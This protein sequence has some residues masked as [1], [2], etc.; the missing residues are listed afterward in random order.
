MAN[1]INDISIATG[2]ILFFVFVAVVT[3]FIY[4]EFDVT[5]SE[6]NVDSFENKINENADS[7]VGFGDILLSLTTIWFW[8]FTTG[9]FWASFFVNLILLPFRIALLL[10]VI[11]NFPIIG[12]GGG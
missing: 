9:S 10:I 7:S 1:G 11:R 12:S 6:N 8:Q 3:P 5:G 4:V 2:I